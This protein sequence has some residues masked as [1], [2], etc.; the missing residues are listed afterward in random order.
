M[1]A[2]LKPNGSDLML[3]HEDARLVLD[4]T[5]GG[6][7]REFSCLGHEILR[8][9]LPGD[10]DPMATACFPMVPYAN[11]IAD[12]RF[13]SGEHSVQLQP[14]WSADPSPLHGQGWRR[15]WR[16]AEVTGA[17]AT[18]EFHGGGDE[19]PWRYR[20]EQHFQL[21]RT[22]LRVRLSVENLADSPMPA[23][24]GLHPYF[25]D[26]ARA[27]LQAHTPRVWTMDARSLPVAQVPTPAAWSFAQG[28]PVGVPPLDH[29]F[30]DWDGVAVLR[31]PEF[32]L[33][34]RASNCSYLHVFVPRG[35]NF[36]CAEPQTAPIG[37]L[38]PE[39]NEAAMVQPHERYV[40]QVSFEVE[41]P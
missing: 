16:I 20:A 34:L 3:Q 31:W 27:R 5:H 29:C 21:G 26:A 25:A 28:R 10:T 35:A 39:R 38:S 18:L 4:P 14:N 33:H 13:R 22:T 19:W 11:R 24:L 8:R 30:A 15:A 7:I 40:I 6:V 12:G 9:A 17:A 2:Q 32:T 36:F 23:V 37:A 1:A 41:V